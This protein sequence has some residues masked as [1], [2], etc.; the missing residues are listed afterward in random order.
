MKKYSR[1]ASIILFK[2]RVGFINLA[3][4]AGQALRS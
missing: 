3:I 4:G 2:I 1:I